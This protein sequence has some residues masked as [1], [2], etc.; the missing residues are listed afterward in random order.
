MAIIGAIVLLI[1]G[2]FKEINNEPH[3][4]NILMKVGVIGI[5]CC[6]FTLSTW[7]LLSWFLPLENTA[8]NPAY[9]DGTTVSP[10]S[11]ISPDYLY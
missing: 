5:L 7:T 3:T 8:E 10:L 4:P 2:V 1:F 11:Q 9:A 6:W